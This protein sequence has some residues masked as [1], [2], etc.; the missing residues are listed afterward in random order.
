MLGYLAPCCWTLVPQARC[1]QPLESDM[2][3]HPI[4]LPIFGVALISAP[5]SAQP[6]QP[7]QTD[8]SAWITQLQPDQWRGFDLEGVDVYSR[9]NGDQIGDISEPI[10]CSNG[11]VSGVVV[12]GGGDFGLGGQ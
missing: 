11:Q 4:L 6:N 2:R 1:L 9:N 12:W 5:V 8:A 10:F 3:F 7:T